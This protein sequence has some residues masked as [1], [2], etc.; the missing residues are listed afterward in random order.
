MRS[1]TTNRWMFVGSLALASA[2]LFG[3]AVGAQSVKKTL[4]L[5]PPTTAPT[6]GPY[7]LPGPAAGQVV[8]TSETGKTSLDFSVTGLRPNAVYTVW[9]TLDSSKPPFVLMSSPLAALDPVTGTRAEV[10]S[11]SPAGPEDGGFTGGIGGLDPNGFITDASG[12]ATFTKN[13]R[14]DILKEGV[15]PIV[16]SS[17]VTQTIPLAAATSTT[18]CAGSSTATLTVTVDAGY[19][20]V[21]NTSLALNPPDTS[22]AF[23]LIDGVLKPRLV[24]GTV[25]GFA[26]VDHFDGLTH[27]HV[28]SGSSGCGTETMS[29]L[30]GT[31]ANAQ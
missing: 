19:M 20:R 27:G 29:R 22:P 18:P 24:R 9:L 15:A 11:A 30:S 26:V 8:I 5:T 16:L 21:F 14:F 1:R 4:M 10:Q 7:A 17:K 31:L 6:T 28:A 12:K 23:Q 3:G 25:R 13:L 2:V